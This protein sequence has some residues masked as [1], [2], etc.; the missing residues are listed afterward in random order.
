MGQTERKCCLIQRFTGMYVRV[1]ENSVGN[2][3]ESLYSFR[4]QS[5]NIL[6]KEDISS[7]EFPNPD[8]IT[9]LFV[10]P[11]GGRF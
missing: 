6:I 5:D 7:V 9:F 1:V 10:K 11:C 8:K 4:E 3:Y 2:A